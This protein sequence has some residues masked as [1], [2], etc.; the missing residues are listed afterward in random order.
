MAHTA[1]RDQSSLEHGRFAC[2]RFEG[3]ELLLL[4]YY[5]VAAP[6]SCVLEAC[7]AAE[8]D[9]TGISRTVFVIAGWRRVRRMKSG[10]YGAAPVCTGM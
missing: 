9:L 7:A 3:A 1:K 8:D 4:R 10:A 6:A 2:G 5:C